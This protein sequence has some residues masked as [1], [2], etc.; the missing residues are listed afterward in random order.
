MATLNLNRSEFENLVLIFLFDH[1][2]NP[3]Q[4]TNDLFKDFIDQQG[5]KIKTQLM[6]S[7]LDSTGDEKLR[8]K[9]IGKLFDGTDKKSVHQIRVGQIKE[10]RKE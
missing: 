8:Y 6:K 4:I 10:E 7:Y 3:E 5:T 1:V 2:M 9:R